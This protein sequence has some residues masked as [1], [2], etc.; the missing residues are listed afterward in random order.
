MGERCCA[1][2]RRKIGGSE[3]AFV[4]R[5]NVTAK[6]LGMTNTHFV[7]PNGLPE[8]VP[9]GKTAPTSYNVTTARDMAILARAL[10]NEFPAYSDLYS[11]PSFKLG[12][13]LLRS[14]NSLL[15]TYDGAD[16]MKTGFICAAGYNVVGS[17]TRGD[18]H[19]IAVVLGEASGR[20]RALR[21]ASLFEHGFEIYPWKVIFA[22]TLATLPVDTPNGAEAPDLHSI[23]CRPGVHASGVSGAR[24]PMP[25]T[26]RRQRQRRKPRPWRRSPS[27]RANLN[28]KPLRFR[29][30]L[31]LVAFLVTMMTSLHDYFIKDG[32]KNL[33]TQQTWPIK[34]QDDFVMGEI[35]A[36]LHL[37]FDAGAQYVSFYIPAMEQVVCPEALALN[38]LPKILQW[39]ETTLNIASGFGNEY[40]NGRDLIFTGRVDIYSERPVP[41]ELK[42]RMLDEASSLGHKLVFRSTEYV[43]ERN[44][45]EKPRAFISHDTRDKTEIAESLASQLVKLRCPVWYDDYTLKVGDS[46]R[47]SIEKGLRECAKCILILTPNFLS[48]DG[49]SKREYNSIF[50]RE[51]VEKQ[52][53][54]LPIWH[55]VSV[56][57]IYK[58][59]LVLADRVGLQWSRGVEEVAK[60]LLR[61]I[62]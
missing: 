21:A 44:K 22:P 3:A 33:T 41:F 17:A 26:P 59:S 39:Q 20:A 49:W 14:H 46:L 35:I 52:N 51:L 23:V 55:N 8:A 27:L 7:N 13:R 45:Y 43:L 10:F 34:D 4:E 40:F 32:S 58:Y 48:N 57:D 15:R 30:P 6:R 61:V 37:D 53:V 47:Q 16:G 62:A 1:D 50:T 31:Y 36:R 24:R 12:K 2:V 42:Q 19:L 60:R 9:E 18:H 56:K 11:L 25:P 5:M 54:I 29:L 38:E 28:L